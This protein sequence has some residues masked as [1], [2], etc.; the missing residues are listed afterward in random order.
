MATILLPFPSG[1]V[2]DIGDRR[3]G[4]HKS[5][6][7]IPVPPI[8][9][10]YVLFRVNYFLL[11]GVPHRRILVSHPS[12]RFEMIIVVTVKSSTFRNDMVV[13]VDMIYYQCRGQSMV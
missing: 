7:T 11:K 4:G 10:F 8:V 3:R 12:N 5:E 1:I 13:N 6:F 9:R 2:Y